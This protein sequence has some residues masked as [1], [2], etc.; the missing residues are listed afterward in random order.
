MVLSCPA[1]K[2]PWRQTAL[3]PMPMLIPGVA[4]AAMRA[5]YPDMWME[6]L[7]LALL[8]L[9][10]AIELSDLPGYEAPAG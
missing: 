10:R 8:K 4:L 1:G 5:R 7:P 6:R 2:R 3:G 9:G